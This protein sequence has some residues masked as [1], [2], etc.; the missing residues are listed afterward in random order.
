MRLQFGKQSEE[1]LVETFK[2]TTLSLEQLAKI[3][4][5]NEHRTVTENIRTGEWANAIYVHELVPLVEPLDHVSAQ[6]VN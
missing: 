4:A 6:H 2:L 1:P 5:H 3:E